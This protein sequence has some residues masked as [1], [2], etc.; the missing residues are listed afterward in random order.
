MLTTQQ[1]GLF[2]L[3]SA[4][5]VKS[6]CAD[7]R[8]TQ[9]QPARQGWSG[10]DK[11]QQLERLKLNHYHDDYDEHNFFF[12]PAVMTTSGRIRGDFLALQ[13]DSHAHKQQ[14]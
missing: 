2:A 12:L 13:S 5:T 1:S 10:Q 11:A 3:P 7:T 9:R 14:P 8:I 4:L 6:T